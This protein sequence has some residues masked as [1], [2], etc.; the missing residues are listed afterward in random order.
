MDGAIFVCRKIN[1]YGS[2]FSVASPCCLIALCF[3]NQAPDNLHGQQSE[4]DSYVP[5]A[6]EESRLCPQIKQLSVLGA[7][8]VL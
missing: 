1:L 7:Q 4:I 8:V 2:S 3:L 5:R 6:L